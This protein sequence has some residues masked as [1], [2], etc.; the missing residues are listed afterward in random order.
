MKWKQ[1][2]PPLPR[3]GRACAVPHARPGGPTAADQRVGPG[4]LCLLAPRLSL[5]VP[6]AAHARTK[7]DSEEQKWGDGRRGQRAGTPARRPA[8]AGRLNGGLRRCCRG[9]QQ[10]QWWCRTR[11]P[12][13][14]SRRFGR[15]GLVFFSLIDFCVVGSSVDLFCGSLFPYPWHFLPISVADP[16]CLSQIL[17][18]YIPD[19]NF[20]HP[21]SASKNLS[22]LIQEKNGSKLSEI[23]S[24]WLIPDPDPDFLPI[25]DP[26]LRGQKATGSRIRIR[27]TAAHF[28]FFTPSLFVPYFVENRSNQADFFLTALVFMHLVAVFLKVS[29]VLIQA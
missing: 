15:R 29:F 22:I 11:F 2:P 5:P 7:R 14:L 25:P 16:G 24:G 4:A 18:F 13:C 17:I 28:N 10:W 20:F 19:P 27:N 3:P 9:C 26:G 6:D 12:C 21:G 1:A 8:R 23:W